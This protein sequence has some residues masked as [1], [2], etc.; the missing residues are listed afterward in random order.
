MSTLPQPPPP[1]P[2][3]D[4]AAIRF[5][6]PAVSSEINSKWTTLLNEF[7]YSLALMELYQECVNFHKSPID[8][9]EIAAATELILEIAKIKCLLS[10]VDKSVLALVQ[11]TKYKKETIYPKGWFGRP[12]EIHQLNSEWVYMHT[13]E[14]HRITPLMDRAVLNDLNEK[15]NLLIESR[16]KKCREICF[17]IGK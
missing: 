9:E 6:N 15:L 10:V 7:G 12:P 14:F 17:S 13:K 4:Y 16:D 3:I 8:N 2:S 11:L 1:P 5:D